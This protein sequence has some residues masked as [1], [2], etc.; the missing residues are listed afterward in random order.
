MI[1]HGSARNTCRTGTS[2][3]STPL[4]TAS[5]SAKRI[6]PQ[7]GFTG[8]LMGIP[9][10]GRHVL[11]TRRMPTAPAM[12]Q[13]PPASETSKAS[14]NS[15]RRISSRLDPSAMRSAISFE[16]S[17]ARAAKRLPRFA[18]AASRISPASSIS[19]AMKAR[20]G[21]PACRLPALAA[22]AT[23]SGLHPLSDRPCPA[24]RRWYSNRLW[25]LERRHARLH[26]SHHPREVRP[27]ESSGSQPPTAADPPSGTHRSA[28]KNSSVP[29][30]SRGAT[31][32]IT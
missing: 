26:V 25:P 14:V 22:P 15:W 9:G 32:M 16:R 28:A 4:S 8:T 27:R 21:R 17:A 18:H 24:K 2:A 5:T 1:C 3:N 12:P 30:N 6:G 31:P 29:R 11:S 10:I 7:V 13:T 23:T 20:A 19:P